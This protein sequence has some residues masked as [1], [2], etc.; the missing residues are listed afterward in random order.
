MKLTKN[1]ILSAV[2]VVGLLSTTSS[3]GAQVD[4]GM[5][6]G[7]VINDGVANVGGSWQLGTFSGYTDATGAAFFTG[8]DYATLQS[9]WLPFAG[10]DAVTDSLGQFYQSV[11]LGAT[12]ANTRLF[13]WGYS[14]PTASASANWSILSGTIGG[15]TIYD[16]VWLAP[17]P[18]AI[19]VNVIEL[20]VTSNVLYANNDPGNAL[21][22]N[23]VAPGEGSAD[24]VLVPEP[25]TY[26]LLSLAGIALG[27][28]AARRR[29]RA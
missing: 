23:S 13:A 25:S 12:A 28:Y 5:T 6:L 24:I 10:S 2:A 7:E 21:V 4:Y 29:R 16:G 8:K 18:S 3:H 27:G 1:L 22:A 14:T 20:G 9:S 19:D 26:A 17:S 11:D 15:L